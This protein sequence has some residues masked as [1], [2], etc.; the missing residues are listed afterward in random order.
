LKLGITIK[1]VVG[2]DFHCEADISIN[3]WRDGKALER[4]ELHSNFV[5]TRQAKVLGKV[6]VTIKGLGGLR[7]G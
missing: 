4:L 2:L 6:K 3:R 5:T 1:K 7:K